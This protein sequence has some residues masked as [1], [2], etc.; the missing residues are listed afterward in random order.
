MQQDKPEGYLHA[1]ADDTSEGGVC[2]EVN[3][4]LR[5]RLLKPYLLKTP[6]WRWQGREG[7]LRGSQLRRGCAV[8]TLHELTIMIDQTDI[9]VRHRERR[10][11][12]VGYEEKDHLPIDDGF[13]QRSAEKKE[14]GKARVRRAG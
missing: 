11:S 2:N 8:L 5:K 14:G 7:Y 1:A 12:G 6:S 3:E 9:H 13:C 4:S 10:V